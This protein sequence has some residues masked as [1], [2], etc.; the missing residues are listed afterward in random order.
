MKNLLILVLSLV[1]LGCGGPS[2]ATAPEPV[3]ETPPWAELPD[4]ER[5]IFEDLLQCPTV[6]AHVKKVRDWPVV[7]G[8]RFEA[9]ENR[10][11]M[12]LEEPPA[13]NLDEAGMAMLQVRTEGGGDDAETV[14]EMGMIS[15]PSRDFEATFADYFVLKGLIDGEISKEEGDLDVLFAPAT[16]K[17]F[18]TVQ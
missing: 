4:H 8:L 18:C 12:L 1:F 6:T 16:G 3:Q 13:E 17:Y 15:W 7:D 14:L 9:Y 5:V 10:F 2:K 11:A